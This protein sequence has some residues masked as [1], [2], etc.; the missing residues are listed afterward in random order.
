M[1]NFRIINFFLK[2][3]EVSG[4]QDSDVESSQSG[5]DALSVGTDKSSQS[6][7]TGNGG[8]LVEGTNTVLVTAVSASG[9]KTI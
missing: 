8:T 3:L 5:S 7:L 6:G 4:S 2:F 9:N 1:C